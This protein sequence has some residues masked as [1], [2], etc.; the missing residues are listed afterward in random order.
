[1]MMH[2]TTNIKK[3]S[4][5]LLLLLYVSCTIDREEFHLDYPLHVLVQGHLGSTLFSGFNKAAEIYEVGEKQSQWFMYILR[6]IFGYRP[7]ICL[8]HWCSCL[9][10]ASKTPSIGTTMLKC[11]II[12][13][14]KLLD[15]GLK[16][17]FCKFLHTQLVLASTRNFLDHCFEHCS[18]H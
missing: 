15:S 18:C 7:Q 4:N 1:M 5:C 11:W 14:S 6:G 16:E 17:L 13:I 12:R 8:L 3:K 10:V 9:L 2:W